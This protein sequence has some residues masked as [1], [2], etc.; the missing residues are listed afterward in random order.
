VALRFGGDELEETRLREHQDVRVRGLEAPEVGE[1]LA[2]SV[3]LKVNRRTL[4]CRSS[5][6]LSVRPRRARISMTEGLMVL[7]RNSRS[8][9]WCASRSVTRTP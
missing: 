2:P 4:A 1:R 3:G 7:P 5:S 9:L 6:T 8:K